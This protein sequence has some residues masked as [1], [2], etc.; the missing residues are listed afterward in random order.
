MIISRFLRRIA[1]GDFYH[2]GFLRRNVVQYGIRSLGAVDVQTR[3]ALLRAL[4][5]DPYFE[6]RAWAAQVLGELF[7]ADT[8]I[9][10]GL[11]SALD[12]T[13]PEVVVRAL[14]ALGKVGSE[15]DLLDRL[16]RFYRHPNWQFRQGVVMALIEF[17]KRGVLDGGQ[18]E[19]DLDKVLASTPHFRPEFTLNERLRELS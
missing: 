8:E 11:R 18:L 6:V 14:A 12:D 4:S 9:E 13:S 15:P 3:A 5:D 19:H 2:V 17:V 1:G 7:S 10:D 16:R